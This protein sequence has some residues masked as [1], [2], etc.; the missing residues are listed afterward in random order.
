MPIK[1]YFSSFDSNINTN[2]LIIINASFHWKIKYNFR[3]DCILCLHTTMLLTFGTRVGQGYQ[4]YLSKV[5]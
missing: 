1:S 4:I 3:D 5:Q 2:Q